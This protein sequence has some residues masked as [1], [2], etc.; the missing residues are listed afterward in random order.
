MNERKERAL[1]WIWRGNTTKTIPEHI[2]VM[3][4][5]A[6]EIRAE[7]ADK[8]AEWSRK[9]FPDGMDEKPEQEISEYIEH[10]L[11]LAITGKEPTL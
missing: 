1:Y 10:G 8:A 2:E 9:K 6:D 5:F 11:R 3:L 4:A 7:S